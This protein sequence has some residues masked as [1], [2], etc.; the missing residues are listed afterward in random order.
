[1][2]LLLLL[3]K[4][5]PSAAAETAAACLIYPASGTQQAD[6]KHMPDGCAI[7]GHACQGVRSGVSV[8][9]G[10][11]KQLTAVSPVRGLLN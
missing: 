7:G 2:L 9:G 8:C 4:A 6:S 1:M 10:K 3:L 5:M 11:P